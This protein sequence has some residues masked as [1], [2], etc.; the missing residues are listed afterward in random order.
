M[1]TLTK[2]IIDNEQ[3]NHVL[4]DKQLARILGGSDERRYGLI[5]RAIEAGELIR[6]KRGIYVL[7]DRLRDH[8]LHPFSLAQRLLPGSYISGETALS[9]HGWIPEVVRSILSVMARDKS[10]RENIS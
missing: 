1:T 4:S 8:P 5:N 3:S 9:F 2:H 10:V 7:A 6:V